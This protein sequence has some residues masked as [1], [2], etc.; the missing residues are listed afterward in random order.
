M[1]GI[2]LSGHLSRELETQIIV[3]FSLLRYSLHVTKNMDRHSESL[4]SWSGSVVSAIQLKRKTGA[5]WNISA[6]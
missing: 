2:T 5:L 1:Y 3:R 6:K 4:R